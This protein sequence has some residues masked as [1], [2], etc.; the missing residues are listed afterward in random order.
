MVGIFTQI[1]PIC[2][3]LR[4]ACHESDQNDI[5]ISFL[6]VNGDV[7]ERALDELD[8]S[9]IYTTVL[10]EILVEIE[11]DNAE[12]RDFTNFCRQEFNDNHHQLAIIDE[13]ER[14]Y[15]DH[16]PIWWYT[17]ESFM[18]PI[19]NRA[20]RLM[21]IETIIKMGFFIRDLHRQ[22]EQL[23]SEQFGGSHQSES[24][25]VYQGQSFF[26]KDLEKIRTSK[27]GLVSFNNFL[28]TS[29]SH[30]VSLDFAKRA[31]QRPDMIGVLFV[32]NIDPSL[33]TTPFADV[34]V[35]SYYQEESE[36]LFSM[37]SVF[38]I[39]NVEPMGDNNRLW[40][41]HLTLT[42][43]TD[44]ELRSLIDRIREETEE[45]TGWYRL[46]RL[47]LKLS[48]SERAEEIYEMLLKQASDETEK[49]TIYN[50]LG[51]VKDSKGEYTVAIH[52]YEKAIE[53]L[54]KIVSSNDPTLAT[55]YNNIGTAYECMGEYSKALE[56]HDKALEIRKR[57]LP[58]NHP[59]LAQSYNNLGAVYYQLQEHRKALSCYE[60]GLVLFQDILPSNHP[61]LATV[62]NNIGGAY[63][64][65]GG[66]LKRTR[67]L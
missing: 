51:L 4:N 27:G 66:S 13:V 39:N 58:S 37:N 52:Y 55:S 15:L 46:G 33:S 50:Q 63:D 2:D 23:H 64:A 44:L 38:L 41:V 30:N 5:S 35:A 26:K 32:M 31:G 54:L 18:Y 47:L 6:S 1:E 48:Q 59:D 49:A 19:L 45:S 17:R 57:A 24:F 20:L 43:D 36:I 10:K 65:L 42:S 28:S 61:D 14:K 8:P 29:I 62:L 60:K 53:N 21:N 11:F 56:M 3:A 12:R 9:F 22:I 34:T 7:S 67:I 16:S 25:I 40:R